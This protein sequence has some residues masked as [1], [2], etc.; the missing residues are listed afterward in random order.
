MKF[1]E[2]AQSC[3][4]ENFYP[5]YHVSFSCGG[6]P[7]CSGYEIHCKDCGIY[8]S[9]CGCG[10]NNGLSGWSYKRHRHWEKKKAKERTKG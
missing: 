2:K 4:H 3:K 5:D 6:T 10:W 8:I 1:W 9:Q 7:Y